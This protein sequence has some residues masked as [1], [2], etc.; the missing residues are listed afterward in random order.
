MP[1]GLD[2]KTRS[3]I[4]A[5]AVLLY[6]LLAGNLPFDRDVLTTAS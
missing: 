5:L 1:S 6:E 4:G 2:I 3:D